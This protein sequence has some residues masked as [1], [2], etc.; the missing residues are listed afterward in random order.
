MEVEQV[1]LIRSQEEL[2][3]HVS[4]SELPTIDF[5]INTLMVVYGVT[6]T[7]VVNISHQLQRLS[8]KNYELEINVLLSDALGMDKWTVAIVV[9]KMPE[10][11]VIVLKKTETGGEI[12]YPIVI[13]TT[14]FFT[15]LDVHWKDRDITYV[16]LINSVQEWQEEIVK[17]IEYLAH[18]NSSLP[19]ISFIDFEYHSLMVVFGVSTTIPYGVSSIL[20]QLSISSYLLQIDVKL[21]ALTQ[22]SQWITM[23]LIPKKIPQDTVISLIID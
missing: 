18:P 3:A 14:D 8:E 16:Y 17:H 22:P 15:H 7:E 9:P 11:A 5:S 20:Q 21:T 12:V 23:L 10:D 6:S 19:D 4:C 2:Q 1:Y 13:E